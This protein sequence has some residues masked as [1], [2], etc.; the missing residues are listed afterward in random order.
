MWEGGGNG[1]FIGLLYSY[2]L[3]GYVIIERAL[4]DADMG[5][6]GFDCQREVLLALSNNAPR[7]GSLTG[8]ASISIRDIVLTRPPTKEEQEEEQKKEEEEDTKEEER[9]M[10]VGEEESYG[11]ENEGEPNRK[12]CLLGKPVNRATG[13]ETA[14][15]TDLTVGGRG[16]ALDLTRTYNSLLAAH[17]VQPGSF[18]FGWT[19]PY[20]AH[21]ELAEKGKEAIVHQEDGSTIRYT[22]EEEHIDTIRDASS[23]ASWVPSSALVEATLADEGSGYVYTLP[24]QL[25]L[26]FN[27]SG[28]LTSEEDRNGSALTMSR[29]SK[30]QLESVTDS[31]GRKITFAYDSEGQVESASDPMGHTVKYAYEGGNLASVTLPGETSPRWQFKYNSSHELASETDG[32]GNTITT[33]YNGYHQVTAQTDAMSRKRTWKYTQYEQGSE[34][35]ITEPNGA[36]TVEQF[37]EAGE[38]TSVTHAASTSIA[39]TAAYEYNGS[40]ELVAL[41]DPDLHKTE[42]GYNANGDLTSE[43]N[44]DGDETKW[45]Y[46]STHD[47]IGITTP[48]GE[49]TTVERDSHGNAI[50]V[51]RPAPNSEMQV[52]KYK[53]DSYGDVES[54]TNPL[55]HEW[56]YEYDGYGD[57]T[58]EI[59]PEDDKRTFGYNEDSQ[60]TST[61]SP[62]GNGH[63]GEPA[64]YTTIIER[65]AQGRV[66]RVIEPLE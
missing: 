48:D 46:D 37:N 63:G 16:P 52:T 49:K 18:G 21:L 39:A 32:R 58:A 26:H 17:Q 50:S 51:S 29:N 34:T 5:F 41:T 20:S 13:D 12:Y 60:E 24:D 45:E 1:Q 11:S 27:S 56:K 31:A 14:T 40:G 44:A 35:R 2:C 64:K 57:R 4:T 43:K 8:S 42:Y 19:G 10:R 15:Q 55:G 7:E 47:V 22:L 54:M 59:D 28:Q 38:P 30:G 61:T 65:D 6:S 23:G 62:R 36:T 9:R 33:E 66:V 3:D 25:K 53:Y